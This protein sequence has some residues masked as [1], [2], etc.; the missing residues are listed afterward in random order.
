M[1]TASDTGRGLEFRVG[2]LVVVSTAILIGFIFVLGNFSLRSHKSQF[3]IV[4]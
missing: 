1:A 3:N 2:L 4:S